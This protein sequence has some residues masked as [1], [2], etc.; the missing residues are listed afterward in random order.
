MRDEWFIRGAVPMTKSEVRAVSISKLELKEDSILW[1]VGAGTGSVSV[2]ASFFLPKGWVYA[3][4]Q[5]EEALDLI[6]RNR[7]KFHAV[8]VTAVKGRAPEILEELPVPTHLFLGGGGKRAGAVLEEAIRRNPK[9]RVVANIIALESIARI[10]SWLEGRQIEAQIVQMQVS[11]SKKMGNCHLMEGQNP[12]YI[13]A[14][15]GEEE[16][17]DQ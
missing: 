4:E 12:V 14:F 5:K 9:V 1:D 17:F 7:E 8:N 16:L 2:V 13:I 3:V 6:E 15:G 10:M 11:R